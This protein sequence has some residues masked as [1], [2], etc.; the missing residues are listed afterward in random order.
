LWELKPIIMKKIFAALMGIAM[1]LPACN[2]NEQAA[3]PSKS[4]LVIENILSRRSVR[5]YLP[6]QIAKDTLDII[7][8]AAINAPSASNKQPW[9][10]R[11]IQNADLL[12]QIRAINERAIFNAPTLIVIA[13]EK[14]NFYGAFDC[15]LL[16]QNILLAAE[17]FN[18]GTCALGGVSR[19]INADTVESKA[20]LAALNIPEGYEVILGIALG[21]KNQ[22]PEAKP[23]DPNKVIVID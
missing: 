22:F 13:C 17:S 10:V 14:S 23:R 19:L 20:I 2:C 5:D 3:I 7:I 18:L 8:N 4:D 12:N 15:G 9:A 21:H 1:L 11:V 16:T 6:Q